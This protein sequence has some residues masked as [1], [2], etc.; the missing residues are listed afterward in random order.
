MVAAVH[1]GP[2][3]HQLAE[4]DWVYPCHNYTEINYEP[5]INTEKLLQ[6]VAFYLGLW[7]R[8]DHWIITRW[9]TAIHFSILYSFYWVTICQKISVNLT[10]RSRH[11]KTISIQWKLEQSISAW[12]RLLNSGRGMRALLCQLQWVFSVLLSKCTIRMVCKCD[13]FTNTNLTKTRL[14]QNSRQLSRFTWD[15]CLGI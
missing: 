12:S 11:D 10:K 8:M 7:T 15:N 1:L 9:E 4:S 6:F 14:I 5:D 3:L 2:R 13:C